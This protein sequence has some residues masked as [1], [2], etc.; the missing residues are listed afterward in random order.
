M[1]AKVRRSGVVVFVATFL[2]LVQPVGA[3]SASREV[4]ESLLADAREGD[5]VALEELRAIT[6]VDGTPVD[7]DLALD[8]EDPIELR[9]RLDVLAEGGQPSAAS[10]D[11][12]PAREAARKILDEDEFTRARLPRPLKG[13]IE[14]IA[15]ALSPL[16][17]ALETVWGNVVSRVLFVAA[18]LGSGALFLTVLARRRLRPPVETL[19]SAR[20]AGGEALLRL[21]PAEL[22]RLATEAGRAGAYDREIRLR[23]VAG[24]LR[25]ERAGRIRAAAVSP[26]LTLRGEVADPTFDQLAASFDEVAYGDRPATE[27]DAATARA[28]WAALVG[29]VGRAK[30]AKE[31]A[32]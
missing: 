10:A 19:G 26:S 6:I 24:L 11:P 13:L 32:A 7:L 30:R 31:P 9:R 15:D 17:G 21:D 1:T 18:L 16:T 14:W 3:T 2:L 12:E 23:F 5:S 8:T 28:G 22:D 29:S 20:G 4:Y 25:L 27:A